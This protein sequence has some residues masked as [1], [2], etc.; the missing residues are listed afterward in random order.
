MDS[1]LVFTHRAMTCSAPGESKSG[2]QTTELKLQHSNPNTPKKAA[3]TIKTA[4]AACLAPDWHRS[5]FIATQKILL[6]ERRINRDR[7]PVSGVQPQRLGFSFHL[8][9][10]SLF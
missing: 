5:P 8:N 6:R 1:P 4:E 10:R 9:K 2:S 3:R 7:T